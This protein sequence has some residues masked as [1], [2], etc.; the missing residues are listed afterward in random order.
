VGPVTDILNAIEEEL[1]VEAAPVCFLV[2]DSRQEGQ[3][4]RLSVEPKDRKRGLDES[5]EEAVA[6]WSGPP[7][8]SAE[9]LSV[10]VDTD[11]INIRHMKSLPPRKGQVL[12]IYKPTYLEALYDCWNDQEWAPRCEKAFEG[13]FQQSIDLD[14][15]PPVENFPTLRAGQRR[16]FGLLKRRYGFLWGPPGTGKT[17]TLGAMLAQ[18]LSERTNSR[19]LLLS[20]TN[21]SVDLA[22]IQVDKH[23]EVLS[24]KNAHASRTREDCKRIGM[25]F[26]PSEY[27]ERKHLLPPVD[28]DLF[29]RWAELV[30]RMPDPGDVYNYSDWKD[31][32]K[33]LRAGISKPIDTARLA[34]MTTTGAAFSFEPLRKRMPYDLVVF[35]EASQVS[36]AY[37]LALMPLG[38]R[39]VFAGDD[40]QLA[41]IVQSPHPL[42]KEWLGKSIFER[43]PK[44]GACF[45][46]E[47]SRME[48]SI[49]NVVSKVF[50]DGRLVVAQ[51][52]GT[53]A[54][55]CR[56]REVPDVDPMGCK[57]VYLHN[58]DQVGQVSSKHDGHVRVPSADFVVTLVRRLLET[59]SANR[60]SILCPY[61]DQRRFIHAA[62]RR[63]KISNVKVSTV[64]RAQGSEC[65]TVIFDVVDAGHKF[66]NN[67]EDG[68]RLLNVALSRAMARLVIVYSSSDLQ[69]VWLRRIVSQVDARN[70]VGDVYEPK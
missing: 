38:K 19:I 31:K 2:T 39:V 64:H 7:S 8:G 58:C 15:I 20:T 13:I 55:W 21:A 44:K 17:F 16:A 4:W 32:V 18:F 9:V 25:Y 53:D 61:R 65:H 69:N 62:L 37:A 3:V 23:L 60:I 30:A 6:W 52:C 10:I 63:Q 49:C 47:Q 70:G 48:E 41:P 5:L 42:A 27:R 14:D 46:D 26:D 28:K 11:E 1:R 22:L 34:A 43:K 57:N 33:A 56:A 51:D 66:L 24:S 35:D 67:D 45:L 59:T 54:E 50:Y 12:H 68:P 36:L 29:R 40:K